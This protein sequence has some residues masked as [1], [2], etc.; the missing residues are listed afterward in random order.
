MICFADYVVFPG[1]SECHSRFRVIEN[2]V[3]V[4]CPDLEIHVLELPKFRA[5][6]NAV[7]TPLDQW[8][9]FLCEAKNLDSDHRPSCLTLPTIHKA[10][11]ELQM[12]SLN[13]ADHELY[14]ERRA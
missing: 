9:F 13:E 12:I 11:E 7:V 5:D 2:R 6:A 1:D 8:L 3:R 10:I 14:E 4:L